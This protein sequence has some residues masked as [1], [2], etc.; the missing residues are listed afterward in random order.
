MVRVIVI[1]VE[2]ITLISLIV[3]MF[4]GNHFQTIISLL[5]FIVSVIVDVSTDKDWKCE[6]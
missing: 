6:L 4:T 2:I 3:G 5:T 1:A